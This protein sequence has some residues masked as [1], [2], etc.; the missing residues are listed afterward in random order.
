MRANQLTRRARLMV[1][2]VALL[3]A[4]GFTFVRVGADGGSMASAYRTCECRSLEWQ[5]YDRTP[6][7]GPRRTLCIG[8]FQ[9]R[10]CYQFRT[11]PIV[12]CPGR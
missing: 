11:G 8:Y 7:D 3:V 4:G 6:A 2:L 9:S 10:T 12:P 5:L 1:S